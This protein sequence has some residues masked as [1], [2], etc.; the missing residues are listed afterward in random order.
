MAEKS[1]DQ[2]TPGAFG[3]SDILGFRQRMESTQL[4]TL[5]DQHES[6]AG[7]SAEFRTIW[8]GMVVEGGQSDNL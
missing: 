4:T 3:M 5:R 2:P 8:F 6:E 7:F 1:Q